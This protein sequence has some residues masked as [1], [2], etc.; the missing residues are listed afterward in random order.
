M[1]DYEADYDSYSYGGDEWDGGGG[2]D[3]YPHFPLLTEGVVLPAAAMAAGA[4]TGVAAGG[5]E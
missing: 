5:C 2:G 4:V 3:E 1:S